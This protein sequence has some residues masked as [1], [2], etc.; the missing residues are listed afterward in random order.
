MNR[1]IALFLAMKKNQ[2]Q[3][4]ERLKPRAKMNEKKQEKATTA[5]TAA[6]TLRFVGKMCAL[7][8]IRKKNPTTCNVYKFALRTTAPASCRARAHMDTEHTHTHISNISWFFFPLS[9]I[10]FIVWCFII[11]III[12]RCLISHL[13]FS[14][15]SSSF[16]SVL[17]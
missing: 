5:A 9:F 2:Q 16:F 14:S 17:I 11:I 1:T 13:V 7:R 6:T 4:Y 8:Y 12:R 10:V 3:R 15:I